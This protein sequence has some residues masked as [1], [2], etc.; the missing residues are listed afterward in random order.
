MTALDMAI[1]ENFCHALQAVQDKAT[2]VLVV[3]LDA[4]GETFHI[5]ELV[6]VEEPAAHPDL[7]AGV[8]AG[9]CLVLAL[10]LGER[11]AACSFPDLE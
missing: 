3:A 10:I 9:F 1:A 6:L 8:A 7:V 4:A 11:T 5:L 2:V